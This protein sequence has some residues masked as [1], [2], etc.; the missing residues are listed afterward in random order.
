MS[1]SEYWNGDTTIYVNQRHKAA[2]YRLVARDII[3]LLPHA[4]ASAL[5]YGCGEAL[6]ADAIAAR[7]GHLY[8]CDASDPVRARLQQRFADHTGIS[9]VAPP[10]L[11]QVRDGT[12][13]LIVANSVLQYLTLPE[14][15]RALSLWRAKLSPGG[16]LVL[17]DLI[18]H[19]VGLLTDALALLRFA[20]AE[21]FLLAAGA[22]LLKT[23]FSPYRRTR[24]RHGVLRFD[25]SEIIALL[26]KSG[27]TARRLRTNL[28]H[29]PARLAV[30]A[31]PAAQDAA[32]ADA[33]SLRAA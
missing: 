17:A 7:C 18:P 29:N 10:A 16:R 4:E 14:L 24:A 32:A 5:D 12:I 25:E 15:G 21:G 28:G 27:F 2:H 31:G 30:I 22:G 3:A 26:E 11:E 6:Y 13:D 33:G 19:D 9:V 20:R 8:L 1:W 23:F